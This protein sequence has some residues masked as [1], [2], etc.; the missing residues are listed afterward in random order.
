MTYVEIIDSY[1]V[2]LRGL[3]QVLTTAGI[4]VVSTS[5]VPVAKP[6]WYADVVLLDP[7]VF[8]DVD[9]PRRISEYA[10]VCPQLIIT[11]DL[12]E[13]SVRD[14]LRAGAIG[15]ISR[16]EPAD[17]LVQAIGAAVRGVS[18]QPSAEDDRRAGPETPNPLSRRETE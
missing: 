3:E 13:E 4:R 18:V 5:T 12:R 10:A 17:G 8:D 11:N 6:C 1:P 2:F 7:E 14:Y 15:A 16:L 9:V